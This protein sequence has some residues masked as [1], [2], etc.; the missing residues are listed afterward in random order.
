MSAFA[1]AKARAAEIRDSVVSMT[2]SDL[3]DKE[4]WF[5]ALGASGAGA[6]GMKNF[7]DLHGPELR[8]ALI[9]NLECVGAGEI[10]YVDVEGAGKA[11]PSDR[12]LQSLVRAASKEVAGHEMPHQKLDWRDTDATPALLEGMRAMSIMGFDG[13]APACWH[14]K[15]DTI[16]IVDP[17]NLEYVTKVLLK[18]IE[19]A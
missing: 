19:E 15:T 8:G 14:W 16:D 18:V 5:V 9:I 17:D 6:Q 3:L 10:K 7:I 13:V 4:V 2:E 12:R 1:A 11:C